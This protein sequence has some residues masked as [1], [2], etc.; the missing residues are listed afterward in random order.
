MRERLWIVIPAAG[1]PFLLVL[2]I[3]LWQSLQLQKRTIEGLLERLDGLEAVEQRDRN[4]NQELMKQQLGVLQT[5]QKTLQR[6]ISNLENW[7]RASAE[8]ERALWNR[9]D[10]PFPVNQA[11]QQRREPDL[12]SA[13]EP[14]LPSIPKISPMQP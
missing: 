12:E 8:R 3:V 2:F 11:P 4:D 13:A 14:A 6:Q 5:R 10:T 7:Q 9:L 1:F